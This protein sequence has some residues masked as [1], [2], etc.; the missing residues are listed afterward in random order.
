MRAVVQRGPGNT[1]SGIEDGWGK[2]NKTR[3][4]SIAGHVTDHPVGLTLRV[5]VGSEASLGNVGAAD[6]AVAEAV[7]AARA[8]AVAAGGDGTLV[9]QGPADDGK[10]GEQVG[11]RGASRGGRRP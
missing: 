2:L 3:G 11:M 5:W 10:G 4:Q 6:G 7:D 8:V 1:G 9:V